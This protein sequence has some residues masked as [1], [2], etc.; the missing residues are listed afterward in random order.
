MF[1]GLLTFVILSLNQTQHWGKMSQIQKI[2]YFAIRIAEEMHTVLHLHGGWVE[3]KITIFIKIIVTQVQGAKFVI[4]YD[5]VPLP[6][7]SLSSRL[8]QIYEI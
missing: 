5:S 4:V 2:L 1:P 7:N 8:M 6:F 3:V